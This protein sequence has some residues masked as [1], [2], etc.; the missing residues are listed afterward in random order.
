LIAA[1]EY[2]GA[3][4]K[5]HQVNQ[6]LLDVR[7]VDNPGLTSGLDVAAMRAAPPPGDCGVGADSEPGSRPPQQRRITGRPLCRNQYKSSVGSGP[8]NSYDYSDVSLIR[9]VRR[10]HLGAS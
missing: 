4:R 6:L 8:Q 3:P 7:S 10:S 2:V 5:L 1:S 9:V